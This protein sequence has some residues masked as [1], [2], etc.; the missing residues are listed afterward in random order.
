MSETTT[1]TTTKTT[2]NFSMNPMN[3]LPLRLHR[4]EI[5][6]PSPIFS[7]NTMDWLPDFCGYSWIAYGASSLLVISHFPSPLSEQEPKI[8]PIFRQAFELSC[9]PS[10]VV[11][12]LCWSPGLPSTGEIAAAAEN[13]IWVFNNDLSECQGESKFGNLWLCFGQ[14]SYFAF[15]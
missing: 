2:L 5:V 12:S 9:D 6:T 1:S 14:W 7:R 13:C 11:A 4:S 3:D 15:K 10:S 8:G